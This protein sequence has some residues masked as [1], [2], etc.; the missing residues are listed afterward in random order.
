MRSKT[1]TF[2]SSDYE[3]NKLQTNI[4]TTLDD[5]LKCPLINGNLIEGVALVVGVNTIDHQLGRILRGY[6]VVRSSAA[7]T[8]SDGQATNSR[9]D[10]QLILSSS[11][12]STV[13]IWVF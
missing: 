13:S 8:F 11:A 3:L 4:A 10:I 2:N 5:V 1:P 12:A 9:P 7:S 6:I